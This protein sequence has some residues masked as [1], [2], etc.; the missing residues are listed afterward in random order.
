MREFKSRFYIKSEKRMVYDR[1]I[2]R[3]GEC[4]VLVDVTDKDWAHKLNKEL[5]MADDVVE[6]PFINVL[7]IGYRDIYEKDYMDTGESIEEVIFKDGM[8]VLSDSKSPI[9]G[10][11]K[12]VG[13][14]FE[15]MEK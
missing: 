11:Y 2:I 7:D 9:Y 6:M 14:S 15:G 10:A 8:F 1:Q 12:V 5:Y 13:N 3:L 4:V